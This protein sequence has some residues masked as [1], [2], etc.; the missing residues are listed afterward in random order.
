MN[1]EAYTAYPCE[2]EILVT[3]GKQVYIL[4]VDRGVVI[5]NPNASF[6]KY[7]GKTL[8]VVYL[9]MLG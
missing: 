3:E 1:N 5:Q 7:N 8:N 4:S 6:A 9:F 2:R